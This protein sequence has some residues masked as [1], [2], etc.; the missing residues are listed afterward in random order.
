[1]VSRRNS[2]SMHETDFTFTLEEYSENKTKVLV[3]KEDRDIVEYLFESYGYEIIKFNRRSFVV[4]DHIFEVFD[5][6]NS[7]E[8]DESDTQELLTEDDFT[9]TPMDELYEIKY[10]ITTLDTH[11]ELLEGIA[12]RATVIRGGKRKIIFKCGPGQMK[13][14]RSCRRRP[15]TELNKMKRRARVTARKTRSSRRMAVRK[16]K[17]SLKRRAILVR[18]K[19]K[20]KK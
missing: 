6:L 7:F 10:V 9:I 19:P 4:E 2:K 11:R 17:I 8:V 12:K 18:N 14:G 16:R 5:E 13:V 3:S 20:P 1:M 15:T